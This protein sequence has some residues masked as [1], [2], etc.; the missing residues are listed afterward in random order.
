MITAAIWL[1][2]EPVDMRTGMESMCG[3]ITQ[4][5]GHAPASGNAYVFRNRRTTRI[6]ALVW[7]QTGVWLCMRRLHQGSFVWPNME[8]A[9]CELSSVQWEWLIAGV[10]WQRLSPQKSVNWQF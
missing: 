5:L 7:D 6:K 10:D 4:S 1:V 9:F 2:V 3:Q 8:A